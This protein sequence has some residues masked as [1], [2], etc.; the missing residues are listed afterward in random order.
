[1]S[2]MK[3]LSR[4]ALVPLVFVLVAIFALGQQEQPAPGK[5][6][7]PA[8]VFDLK[9]DASGKLSQQQMQE[10]FRVAA[11]KDIENDKR[12]RD[13]TYIERD[14]K[15]RLD[16]K[17][18]VKSTDVT[19]YE[20][21]ELYGEPVQRLIEKDDRAL[22]TEDSA[23]EE[24]K[25]QKIIDKRK[26]ESEDARRKRQQKEEKDREEARKFVHEVADA[27]N[28]R[29]VGTESM[30]GRDTWVIDAE[31]RP[32]YEPHMKEAK[33]LPKFHGRVWIDR[34][35]AQWAKMDIECI[36][37]VSVGWFLARVH[38]GSRFVIEQTRV[39][40]E[41]WLPKHLAIKVDVRLALLKNFNVE[42]D[43]TF[44]DYKKFRATTRIVGLG[45]VQ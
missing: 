44:R 5:P 27:Y 2:L 11:D 16:G 42:L 14:E 3:R 18:D 43:Q 6:S 30:G 34:Q 19:T 38:K 22:D 37:T 35:D 12:L 40:D 28:F 41:V 4:A 32:G 15:H 20:V 45:D 10:L 23:K 36:D 7:I 8:S 17:G 33:F 13:Y 21:M 9:P 1:M 29:L 31:P 25:V 39:N 24:K 26:N